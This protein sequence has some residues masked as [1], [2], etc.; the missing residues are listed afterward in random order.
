VFL[1]SGKE[2]QYVYIDFSGVRAGEL[3][4]RFDV[5]KNTRIYKGFDGLIPLW[6]ESLG[7]ASEKTLDLAA[8]SII[9]HTFSRLFEKS[10]DTH[11]IVSEI[12]MMTEKYFSNP[13]LS[14]S[15]IAEELSYNQKYLSHI[16]KEKTGIGYSEYL[17]SVRLKYAVMLLDQ[18]IDSIKNVAFLSGF[19]DPLYF[20]KVFK[21]QVGY[22]PK[23][24]LKNKAK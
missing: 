21:E 7:R 14:I 12:T 5:T 9:L 16:F 22:S 13:D 3:F 23:D 24:Y 18:G 1:C 19:S 8:E 6:L 4:S 10:P 15:S 20:S 2:I 11:G 17:R